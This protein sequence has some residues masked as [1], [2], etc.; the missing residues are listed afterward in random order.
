[1]N[2]SYL[3]PVLISCAI[4]IVV[5][6]MKK[7]EPDQNKKPNYGMLFGVISAV[8]FAIYYLLNSGDDNMGTVMKEIV[9][10]EPPF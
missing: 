7:D 3:I 6:L 8:S 1:M 5:Y 2:Q 4:V 10:G 9:E